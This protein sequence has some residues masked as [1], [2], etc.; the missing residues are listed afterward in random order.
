MPGGSSVNIGLLLLLPKV[1]TRS[2]NGNPKAEDHFFSVMYL[3]F[4]IDGLT[5]YNSQIKIKYLGI[6]LT[7]NIPNLYKGDYKI[8]LKNTEVDLNKGKIYVI[9]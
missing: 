9:V 7:K 4:L 3:K 1:S 8:L 6:N 2:K 5:T